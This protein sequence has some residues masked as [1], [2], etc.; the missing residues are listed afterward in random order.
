MSKRQR[1]WTPE[2]DGVL[3]KEV[4][5]Q[6]AAN[7]GTVDDWN[8]IAQKIEGR[9]NKDC[10]KRFYNG[11]AGG[12]KKGSWTEEEDRLLEQHVDEYGPAWALIAQTMKT[13][14]ADQCSKRWTH[15]LN[16]ELDRSSWSD[17]ENIT[18][19]KAVRKHGSAWKDIQ[20]LHFPSRSPNNVK[21]QYSVIKR[22]SIVVPED[23][24]PC[25][26]TR[27]ED[28]YGLQSPQNTP[29]MFDNSVDMSEFTDLD[30]EFSF[31]AMDGSKLQE[32]GK[33]IADGIGFDD[34]F[35]FDQWPAIPDLSSS[36]LDSERADHTF[37][38]SSSSGA[39]GF[40]TSTTNQKQ[41]TK[42]PTSNS[43]NDLFGFGIDNSGSSSSSYGRPRSNTQDT[44]DQSQSYNSHPQQSCSN[45]YG[46][47]NNNAIELERHSQPPGYGTSSPPPT[48]T[49]QTTIKLD[50]A[51]PSTVA[52]IM[53]ILIK[54]K[55][56]VKFETQ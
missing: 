35:L 56:K 15:C 19:T 22:K 17:Q 49:T 8:L 26:P 41:P 51:E 16:P 44:S 54:S 47:S 24:P 37:D 38:L 29:D 30:M 12:L 25:C 53:D 13:R 52:A 27:S 11:V 31:D 4:Q 42:T 10:R 5:S 28:G 6:A 34:N 39:R 32:S 48:P 46:T 9:S 43:G 14:S 23:A 21:N 3:Q 40:S 55:A 20:T 2:E 36:T 45:T 50:G 18:L 33:D 7:N 1:R